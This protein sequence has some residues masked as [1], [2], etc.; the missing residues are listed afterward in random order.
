MIREISISAYGTTEDDVTEPPERL[1]NVTLVGDRLIMDVYEMYEPGVRAEQATARV[2]V[3]VASLQ[4][5]VDALV[6]D[7]EQDTD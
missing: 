3:P 5:A 2:E 6:A 1:L 7:Q 4:I